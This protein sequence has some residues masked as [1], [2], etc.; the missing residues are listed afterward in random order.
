M[1]R[2][3]DNKRAFEEGQKQ[4]PAFC[5]NEHLQWLDEL[6]ESGIS[7]M[8]GARPLLMDEFDGLEELQAYAI[9][10]YWMKTFGQATR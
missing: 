7:N 6:R 3:M 1:S 9:L 4:R 2:H 8:F 5:T 10:G